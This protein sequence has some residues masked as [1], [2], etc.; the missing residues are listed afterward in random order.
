MPVRKIPQVRA[1]PEGLGGAPEALGGAP[2]GLGG[3]IVQDGEGQR[4]LPNPIVLGPGGGRYQQKKRPAGV[5][6]T[7]LRGCGD[8]STIRGEFRMGMRGASRD[9]P[10]S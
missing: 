9:A 8:G 10:G 3:A 4:G 7:L 6:R 1:V 2:E 5:G